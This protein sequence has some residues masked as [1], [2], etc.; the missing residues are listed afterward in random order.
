MN[1]VVFLASTAH[2]SVN[3]PVIGGAECA[4]TQQQDFWDSIIRSLA[5]S[6]WASWDDCSEVS[7]LPQKSILH[8]TTVLCD[9]P[10]QSCGNAVWRE[11]FLYL[12]CF[13][14]SPVT[15]QAWRSHAGHS[16][17]SGSTWRK[18]EEPPDSQNWRP[19]NMTPPQ[20]SLGIL[21]I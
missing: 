8:I 14:P 21:A 3:W 9:H 15:R 5:S 11:V 7:Q 10:R 17:L 4:W 19:R 13:Q 20:F 2:L 12:Y 6:K 1:K 16:T 18:T